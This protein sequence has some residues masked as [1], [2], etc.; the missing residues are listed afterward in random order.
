V[1]KK[2]N[3][4][5]KVSKLTKTKSGKSSLQN[6]AFLKTLGEH[7]RKI[8]LQKGYTLNGL[9]VS[10]QGLSKAAIVRIENG[11]HAVT[12]TNFYQYA[13]ALKIPLKKLFDFS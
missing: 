11:T 13:R 4:K 9:Y 3:K 12:I 2:T 6:K 10:T 1:V 8:R 5:S 7:C